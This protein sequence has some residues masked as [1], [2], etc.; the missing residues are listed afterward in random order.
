MPDTDL[1][2]RD[3]GYPFG[4]HVPASG[5]P[6]LTEGIALTCG[7]PALELAKEFYEFVTTREALIRQAHE[8][9][10]IPARS[11]IEPEQLPDWIRSV[12]VK[13]MDV[14][15]DRLSVEGPGWMMYWDENIKG[16]G[17]DYL[18]EKGLE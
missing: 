5:T 12:E 1:Q 3:N 2:V 8:F 7:G 10:R 13:A 4:Y 11:D 16:R 17:A 9:H 18:K 14:D 15:W 6:V